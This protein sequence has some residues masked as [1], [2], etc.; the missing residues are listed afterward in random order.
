MAASGKASFGG[1]KDHNIVS[2]GLLSF[3]HS[4]LQNLRWHVFP[5]L[6]SNLPFIP[7]QCC[8]HPGK[9]GAC[10]GMCAAIC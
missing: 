9:S 10:F 2:E 6:C 8:T 1:S 3:S 4:Q 7:L 5:H